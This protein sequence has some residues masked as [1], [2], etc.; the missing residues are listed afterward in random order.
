MEEPADARVLGHR[1]D[2]LLCAGAGL[3]GSEPDATAG[4]QSGQRGDEIGETLA[5]GGVEREVAASDD[6]LM[7]TGVNEAFG[8]VEKVREGVG[9]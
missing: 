1:V 3:K 4:V 5:F 6:N 9:P 2:C 7:V 8:T